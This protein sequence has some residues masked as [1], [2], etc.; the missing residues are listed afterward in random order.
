METK[1]L[2]GIQCETRDFAPT[3][4]RTDWT[5]THGTFTAK[6]AMVVKFGLHHTKG[7]RQPYFSVTVDGYENGKESFGGC[8]H[9]LVLQ[10][11]P[12]LADL[13]ALHLSDIDGSP[14][15]AD[16]NGF[17]WLA[18]VVDMGQ[19]YTG[20][21]G[22]FGKPASECL[23]IAAEHFRITEKEALALAAKCAKAYKKDGTTAAKLVC[24]AFTD[25]QRPRWKREALAAIDRWQLGIYG[26]MHK[27]HSETV[28]QIK[29]N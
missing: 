25:A 5:E 12:A 2:N 3:T 22:D 18:G 26:D 28:A 7:N 27:T 14:M 20:A 4:C 11:F 19:Q 15:H 13:V 23:R 9:E 6:I 24:A 10:H 1:T 29:G 21:S 8:C 17:Y 16:G